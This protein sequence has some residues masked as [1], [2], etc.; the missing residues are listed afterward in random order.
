[1]VRLLLA[2][3][4]TLG[5]GSVAE[6]SEACGNAIRHRVDPDVKLVAGAESLLRAD[7]HRRAVA[8]LMKMRRNPMGVMLARA[9]GVERR[10]A[11]VLAKIV[12][13]SRSRLEVRGVST[14]TAAGRARLRSWARALL[15]EQKR[16]RPKDPAS[17]TDYAESISDRPGKQREAKRVLERLAAKD[18]VTSAHGYAALA[19]LREHA[20]EVHGRDVALRRCRAM[21]RAK[22]KVCG[23]GKIDPRKTRAGDGTV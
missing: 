14:D 7:Q 13:R 2:S 12:I 16:L 5:L 23:L 15:R 1:M 9:S 4:L 11:R 20:G 3:V 10:A 22:K 19:R 17:L 18:L 21:T 8:L 6:H